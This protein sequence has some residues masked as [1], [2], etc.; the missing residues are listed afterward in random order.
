MYLTELSQLED[1]V[2]ENRM[3]LREKYCCLSKQREAERVAFV[4]EKY[5]Q[6]F[7]YL[8]ILYDLQGMIIIVMFNNISKN[9]FHSVFYSTTIKVYSSFI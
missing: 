3:K 5:E 8:N 6:R 9:I 4:Q 1:P 7:R 2:L